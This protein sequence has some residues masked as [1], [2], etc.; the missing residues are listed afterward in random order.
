LNREKTDDDRRLVARG[1]VAAALPSAEV[2]EA[3]RDIAGLVTGDREGEMVGWP[4]SPDTGVDD[5]PTLLLSLLLKAA[6]S[7]PF[8]DEAEGRLL[9]SNSGDSRPAS[10]GRPPSWL[11]LG[12]DS[13]EAIEDRW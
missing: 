4:I 8:S 6:A 3:T 2:C 11:P 12:V 1:P 5:P 7:F 9:P 10:S 13:T